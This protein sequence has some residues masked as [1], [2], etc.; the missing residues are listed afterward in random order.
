MCPVRNSGP[1]AGRAEP[2][3]HI[4]M[5]KTGNCDTGLNR[6]ETR[7]TDFE[8]DVKET[9]CSVFSGRG[10]RAVRQLRK[11][12]QPWSP[13]AGTVAV[14]CLSPLP[15]VNHKVLKTRCRS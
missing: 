5:M 3:V 15:K 14:R 11:P 12:P 13:S 1:L 10:A 9:N 4:E 2:R 8:D 7:A 6:W